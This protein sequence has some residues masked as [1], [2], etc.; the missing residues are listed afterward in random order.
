M[1]VSIAIAFFFALFLSFLMLGHHLSHFLEEAINKQAD[2]DLAELDKKL[3]T[4]TKK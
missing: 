4:M 3:N 2:M 1:F